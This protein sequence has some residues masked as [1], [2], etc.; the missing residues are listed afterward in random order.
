MDHERAE[1]ISRRFIT[2]LETGEADPELFTAD[3]FC[4]FT[5]PRWR[6]QAQ[7]RVDLVQLRLR[8][9]PG[10]GRVPRSRCDPTPTGFVLEV[11]EEWEQDGSAWYCRELFRADV[12]GDS[13]SALAVYCTGDWDAPRRAEHAREVRLLQP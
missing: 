11:E 10:P 3:A 7:G 13:I 2:F 12:R 5:L 1:R 6:L 9:H 8:G 4:D